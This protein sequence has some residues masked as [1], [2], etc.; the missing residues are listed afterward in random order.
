M[1]QLTDQTAAERLARAIV[2]DIMLYNHDAI[3]SGGPGLMAA[4]DEGR[5]LFRSRVGESLHPVFESAIAAS[6]LAPWGAPAAGATYRAAPAAYPY[7][8]APLQTTT[9][10]RTNA[11]VLVFVALAVLAAG[12]VMYFAAQH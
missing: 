5:Q 9:P 2:A 7:R 10:S 4:I 12:A 8:D 1:S 11:P 6:H 3:S